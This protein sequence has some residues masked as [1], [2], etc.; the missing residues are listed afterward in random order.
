MALLL[1]I[2][3]IDDIIDKITKAYEL[4]EIFVDEVVRSLKL[5]ESQMVL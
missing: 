1:S 5:L 4:N 3:K 2:M